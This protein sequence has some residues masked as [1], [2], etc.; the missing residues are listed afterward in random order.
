MAEPARP[1]ASSPRPETG[2]LVLEALAEAPRPEPSPRPLR[3]DHLAERLVD[4][5]LI[6]Y[7]PA[8]Q[9]VHVL[10]PT[11]AFTWRLCDGEHTDGD[12]VAALAERYPENRQAIEED[13][14]E[15]LGLFRTEDLL[16][17]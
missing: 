5:E 8:R 9:R 1:T 10:N 17:V 12:I 3:A 7:D 16:R 6:L 2:K 11:A 14:A 13:V 4:G 15:V